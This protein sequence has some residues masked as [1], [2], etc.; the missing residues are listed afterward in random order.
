[1]DAHHAA[2]L[3][4]LVL[5]LAFAT[6]SVAAD[7]TTLTVEVVDDDGDPVGGIAVEAMWEVGDETETATATTASNGKVFLD[8]EAGADV[9]LTVD[10]ET[11]VRNRPL[12][13]EDASESTVEL[14]VTQSTT[15]TVTVIDA[16]GNPLSD[17]T[18]RLRDNDGTV[19]SGTT[20]DDGD[21][22][23]ERIEH[24]VY[25]IV[26]VKPGYRETTT[27]ETVANEPTETVEIERGRVTL[28]VAVFDD[29]F[30]PPARTSVGTVRAESGSY[31]AEASVTDG[32]ASLNVPVNDEYR[33]VVDAEGYDTEPESVSVDESAVETNV[34]ISR[35]PTL[36]LTL[37]N[38]RVVVGE[39]TRATVENAYDEP[40][41]GATVEI[42]E[43]TVGE[44]N[45][46]G[47]LAVPIEVAGEQ[48]IVA[49]TDELTSETVVVEGFDVDAN[50]E[51]DGDT[52]DTG[53]GE[54]SGSIPGFGVGVAA[55][56]L[57]VVAGLAR[58]ARTE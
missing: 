32:I 22:F 39:T 35:T 48:S 6:G 52:S 7:Q 57:L 28:D 42:D 33:L 24:G 49:T 19:D 58:R 11:Y 26:A 54:T 21:F 23:T 47:E 18:V 5:V 8:V 38:E 2:L 37:A 34:T 16:D 44:T 31:G 12:S 46:D 45:A 51:T 10:D 3:G 36:S 25:D 29:H 15:A 20:D 27:V 56:A 55:L 9:E 13:V 50:D 1:M 43:T 17:A 14:D 30:D 4:T 41:A 40:V 53:A